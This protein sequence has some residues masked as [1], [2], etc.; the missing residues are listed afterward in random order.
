MHTAS[1]RRR[2]ERELQLPSGQMKISFRKE[3]QSIETE[4]EIRK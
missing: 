4:L 3:G 2:P 1:E